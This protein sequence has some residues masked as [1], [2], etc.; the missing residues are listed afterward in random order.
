MVLKGEVEK[1]KESD[2]E[3]GMIIDCLEEKNRRL[4]ESI[5]DLKARSMR[6]N[7]L[8][9]VEE[10]ARG[11][12]TDKIFR[13][14][15]EKLE[16]P[17]TRNKIKIDQKRDMQR[18][19]RAI[20]VKFNFYQDRELVRRNAKKLKGRKIGISEQ[21]PEEIEK[22]RQTLYLKMRKA[23]SQGHQVRLVRDKLFINNI[24]S[25]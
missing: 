9:Y 5:V 22:I 6:D 4:H 1:L 25:N 8:F 7:P 11:N 12:T 16:I 10:K 14:L 17:D 2:R 13:F 21:F 18:K 3:N 20:V 19:T 23:K 24:R 15:E